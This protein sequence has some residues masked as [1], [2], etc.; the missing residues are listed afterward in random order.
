MHFAA[1]GKLDNMSFVGRIGMFAIQRARSLQ[2]LIAL[3]ASAL[4]LVVQPA[5]WTRPVQAVLIKQVYYTGV[6]GFWFISGFALVIG[7]A[8]VSQAQFWM[9]RL[10]QSE[11]LGPFLVTVILRELGPLLVNLVIIGRSGT[12]I[13]TELGSMMIRHEVKLLDAQ[14]LDPM[15][16]LAMPRIF[17]LMLSVFSLTM[18]FAVVA[19]VSGYLFAL[20]MGMTHGYPSLFFSSVMNGIKPTDIF[21]LLAKTLL[22]ALATG[23]ICCYEGMSVQYVTEVPQ[24][25]TRSVVR[26]NFALFIISAV[27]SL[28]TYL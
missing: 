21:N 3:A 1:A 16:Y 11:L 10:G 4:W 18:V 19:F 5:S 23:T 8:V 17:G 12:A 22:P 25:S 15:V 6:Q 28:L 13:A 24:A 9:V 14:G 27:V 20:M 7:L 2:Y 26:S